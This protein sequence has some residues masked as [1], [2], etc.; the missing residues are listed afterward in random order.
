MRTSGKAKRAPVAA[1]RRSQASANSSPPP[2]ARPLMAAITGLL[3]WSSGSTMRGRCGSGAVEALR[4]PPAQNALPAP[5][6]TTT[7]IDESAS[8]AA[9]AAVNSARMSSLMALRL[10][11]RSSVTRAT[12]SST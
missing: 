12:A 6:S 8:N 7:R 1:I 11:G 9:K 2:K 5:V 3:N 4:S 10:S